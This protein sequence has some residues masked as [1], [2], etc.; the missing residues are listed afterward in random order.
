[1]DY[2]PCGR[3]ATAKPQNV[4]MYDPK[5]PH[6]RPCP[7]PGVWDPRLNNNAETRV[8]TIDY[9]GPIGL[10]KLELMHG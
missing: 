4:V 2:T 8:E 6:Y 1:M 5:S 10:P 9:I 7:G 3:R